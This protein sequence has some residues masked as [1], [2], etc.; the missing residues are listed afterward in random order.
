[1]TRL[2][3]VSALGLLTL[4]LAASAHAQ[5]GEPQGGRGARPGQLGGAVTANYPPVFFREDWKYDKTVRNVNNDREPEHP[6]V[7]GDVAN[8][9]LEV[10]LYGDKAGTRAVLQ[11]Y[12]ADITYVMSL[13][14]ESNC[15]ITLRTGTTMWT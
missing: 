14:C 5:R 9:N 1:M 7:Q 8:P 12:N 15:A 4:C 3:Q 11:P 2:I 6:I 10:R 13:L